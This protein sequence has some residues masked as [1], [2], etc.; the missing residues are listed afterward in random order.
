MSEHFFS[1]SGP[2][3]EII[4]QLFITQKLGKMSNNAPWSGSEYQHR[5]AINIKTIGPKYSSRESKTRAS[6][7]YLL[8]THHKKFMFILLPQL[9]FISYLPFVSIRS[10]FNWFFFSTFVVIWALWWYFG[11]IVIYHL[12][13]LVLALGTSSMQLSTLYFSIL[14]SKIAFV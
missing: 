6:K 8:F 7:N 13:A 11:T 14:Q 4:C 9:P 3:F 12:G 2:N 5:S 1:L 10:N